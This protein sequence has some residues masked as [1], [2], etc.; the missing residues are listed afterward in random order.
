MKQYNNVPL[1]GKPMKITL[2]G[3]EEA[4]PE[5]TMSSRIGPAPVRQA[6]EIYQPRGG[7]GNTQRSSFVGRG[8][9][10]GRGAGGR[11]G[12]GAGGRG[13]RGGSR[14]A[15]GGGDDRKAPTK[16][17]LDA[18]LDAYNSKMETN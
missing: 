2:I 4:R 16:E 6:R 13:G 15:R 10:G 11:G 9:G 3:G 8:G 7:Y 5:R 14:G 17:D 12:R 18:Q 1:D